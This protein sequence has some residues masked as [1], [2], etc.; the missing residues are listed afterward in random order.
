MSLL[1]MLTSGSVCWVKGHDGHEMNERC[2]ALATGAA[3]GGGLLEDP[4]SP[5]TDS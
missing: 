4:G 2:D 1:K 5:P 3:D